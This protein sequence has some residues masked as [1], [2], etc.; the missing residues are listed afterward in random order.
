ML[1]P[2]LAFINKTQDRRG[3][4]TLISVL[5]YC[6]FDVFR[7]TISKYWMESYLVC[8]YLYKRLLRRQSVPTAGGV[9]RSPLLLFP[10]L[11]FSSSHIQLLTT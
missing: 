6:M 1:W 9:A 11:A 10:A 7:D 4:A 3:P 8:R 5:F 2:M